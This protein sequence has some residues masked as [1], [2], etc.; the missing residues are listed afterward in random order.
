MPREIENARENLRGKTDGPGSPKIGRQARLQQRTKHLLL[1]GQIPTHGFTVV[2]SVF[3]GTPPAKPLD[4]K[5]SGNLV[6][7][8]AKL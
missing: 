5:I 8:G 7:A 4:C 3:M 6:G 2:L 1:S